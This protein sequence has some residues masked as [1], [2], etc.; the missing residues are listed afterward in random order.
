MELKGIKEF[1]E[2]YK[3]TILRG[4]T[5]REGIIRC[6][7]DISGVELKNSDIKIE[8]GVVTLT[9]SS[10]KKNQI[11][12]FKD[13]IILMIKKETGQSIYEIH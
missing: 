3:Q 1:L 10:I 5:T 11:F 13:H 9:I 8:R 7:K 2:R 4:D 6:I 12:L